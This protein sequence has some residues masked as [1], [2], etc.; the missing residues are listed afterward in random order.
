M[1]GYLD[2]LLGSPRLA[3]QSV[4]VGPGRDLPFTPLRKRILFTNSVKLVPSGTDKTVN[5]P[6]WDSTRTRKDK[7]KTVSGDAVVYKLRIEIHEIPNMT[8]TPYVSPLRF[9][10]DGFFR[11]ED[12]GP[13]ET[14][15]TVKGFTIPQS[16]GSANYGEAAKLVQKGSPSCCGSGKCHVCAPLAASTLRYVKETKRKRRENARE[17]KRRFPKPVSSGDSLGDFAPVQ[18]QDSTN[19]SDNKFDCLEDDDG[20]VKCTMSTRLR[21]KAISLV[22]FLSEDLGLKGDIN[23]LPE[24]I[25]CGHLRS[26]VRSCFPSE[27]PILAELSIKTSQKAEKSCCE[28]CKP[29]FLAK[30]DEWK[31]ALSQPVDVDQDHLERFRFALKENIPRGWNKIPG[32]YIPNGSAALYNKVKDGG[33]WHREPFSE[34]CRYTLVFSSGKPR[35][36]TCYSSENTRVLTPLHK[37]LYTM[38]GRKGWLLVGDPTPDRVAGLNGDGDFLSFDYVGATDNIKSAYTKAAIEALI[39]LGDDLS[40]EERRC[41]RVLGTLR[42]ASPEGEPEDHEVFQ[43]GQPMGSSM[44]FPLLCLINKSVVDLALTDLLQDRVISFKEWTQHR[45]LINGDDLLLREPKKKSNLKEAIIRNGSA[46]GLIVNEEKSGVSDE[47][48]EINSTLFTSSGTVKEKKTNANALY[49]KPDVSDVLGLAYEA[50]STM[51]AFIRVVRAN[52]GLLARQEDKFLWKLPFPYQAAVR[53][54]KKIKKSLLLGPLALKDPGLNIF[55]VVTPPEGYEL[56]REEEIEVLNSEVEKVREKAIF[57]QQAKAMKLFCESRRITDHWAQFTFEPRRK[58]PVQPHNRSWRS[59]TK[60]RRPGEEKILRCLA[61]RYIE[62]KKNRLVEEEVETTSVAGNWDLFHDES[63]YPNMIEYLVNTI[64]ATNAKNPS[65]AKI[66]IS[67]KGN[68]IA[69]DKA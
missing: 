67:M 29:K 25:D 30:L 44:S 39:D 24:R 16:S 61:E 2:P 12:V 22:R 15:L 42:L 40:S 13:H 14:S 53:K 58:V 55:P 38:L 18:S 56:T 57:L 17:G 64:R 4:R 32:P 47:H 28:V 5:A 10:P 36:V 59:M 21:G 3:P 43:R 35:V 11:C 41:L 54:N 8:Y 31:E 52:V 9:A 20:I 33:N 45:C 63:L 68:W 27:L 19:R 7:N 37:S 66:P 46:V 1:V 6:W 60:K 26:A 48:A 34:L 69:F 62:K 65:G 50:T 49:M 51:K 23:S